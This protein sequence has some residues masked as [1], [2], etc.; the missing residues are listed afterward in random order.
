[1]LSSYVSVMDIKRTVFLTNILNDN[2]T[3]FYNTNVYPGRI[4]QSRNKYISHVKFLHFKDIFYVLKMSFRKSLI[5][6][7]ITTV[8]VCLSSKC[9]SKYWSNWYYD[10]PGKLNIVSLLFLINRLN[11]HIRMPFAILLVNINVLVNS[12]RDLPFCYN[13]F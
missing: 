8:L 6:T 2:M 13:F 1:M 5:P 9:T 7:W 11:S 12:V 4:N 10:A 3:F